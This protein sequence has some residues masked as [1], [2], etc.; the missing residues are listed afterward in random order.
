MSLVEVTHPT[1][2]STLDWFN[3]KP[4]SLSLVPMTVARSRGYE[5]VGSSHD[6]YF[7]RQV[8]KMAKGVTTATATGVI[9]LLNFFLL[10]VLLN[11]QY[12]PTWESLD[13]HPHPKWFDEAKIGVF[14]HWGVYSVPSFGTENSLG[15]WFWWEWKGRPLFRY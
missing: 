13:K 7:S 10:A 11:A 6:R 9:L 14:V 15:E 8:N 12:L 1:K 2:D 3:S 4:Y 5:I